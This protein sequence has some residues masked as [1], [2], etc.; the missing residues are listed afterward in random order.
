MSA[1]RAMIVDDAVVGEFW[2]MQF[3]QRGKRSFAGK[4]KD[5]TK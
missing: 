1:S 5:N 4:L 3:V 2:A